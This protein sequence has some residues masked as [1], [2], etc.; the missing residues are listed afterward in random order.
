MKLQTSSTYKTTEYGCHAIH[1]GICDTQRPESDT[2]GGQT[3]NQPPTSSA[4]L[5]SAF[6]RKCETSRRWIVESF[7]FHPSEW[8]VKSEVSRLAWGRLLCKCSFQKTE[9]SPVS[10]VIPSLSSNRSALSAGRLWRSILC[11]V[12]TSTSSED[13]FLLNS[14]VAFLV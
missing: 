10:A 14:H 1:S 8:K 2:E 3:H 7:Y 11:L 13:D 5:W 6:D 4:G 9:W 12:H